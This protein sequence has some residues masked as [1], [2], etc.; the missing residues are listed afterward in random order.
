MNLFLA[1]SIRDVGKDILKKVETITQN[2]Q[3]LFISTASE[4]EQG[5]LSWI[6]DDRK[7]LEGHGFSVEKYTIT[8]KNQSEI[9]EKLKTVGSVCMG[10]GN[11]YYLLF[12]VRKS[13]FD[14]VIQEFVKNNLVYIGASAG[15]MLVG[16]TIETS[17]DDP[18]IVPE[19]TD[20]KG[21]RL[22]D[23]A[24]RPHWGSEYYLKRYHQEMDR[25]YSLKQKMIFLRDD[26]YLHVKD[27]WYQVIS[28]V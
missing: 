17:L 15:S 21:L 28:V 5:D 8:G 26:Q 7:S 6:D 16:S 4:G 22:V 23:V 11:V 10:G 3:L 1:S 25:L 18:A 12:Q 24:I 27:D 2:R 19:L 9:A 14:R 20:Y 13:G